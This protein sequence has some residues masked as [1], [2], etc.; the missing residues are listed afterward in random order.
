MKFDDINSDDVFT[1]G[2]DEVNWSKVTFVAAQI[3]AIESI[4]DADERLAAAKSW[5][6]E[7]NG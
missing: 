2:D 1:D 7:L 6:D 5:V 4:D 3:D